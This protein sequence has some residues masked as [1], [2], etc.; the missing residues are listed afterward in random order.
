[1][2]KTEKEWVI[3]AS[4]GTP[5]GLFCFVPVEGIDTDN[6]VFVVGL[7]VLSD[8]CPGIF[9]GVIHE[10]GQEAVEAFVEANKSAIENLRGGG[11]E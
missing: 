3:D 6:P 10:A 11:D 5:P 9:R 4:M 1:M 8:K 2:S 7:N